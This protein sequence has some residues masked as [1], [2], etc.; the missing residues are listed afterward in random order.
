MT[1]VTLRGWAVTAVVHVWPERDRIDHDLHPGCVCQ[2]DKQVDEQGRKIIWT[3]H[4]L[5][6]RKT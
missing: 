2:P 6:G 1:V 3:H 4:A 5:D